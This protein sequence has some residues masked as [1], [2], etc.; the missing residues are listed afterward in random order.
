MQKQLWQTQITET[1]TSDLEGIGQ[2]REVNGKIY[3]WV[4]NT[5]S[6]TALALGAACC[7][8]FSDAG[9]FLKNVKASA[10]AN[11]N[12]M[13]GIVTSTAG[14]AAGSYGWIQVFG[15]YVDASVFQSQTTAGV[16]GDIYGPVNAVAYLD[17]AVAGGTAAT[18]PRHA[19]LMEA[20]ATVTTGAAGSF[21]VFVNCL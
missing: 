8:V 17:R 16:A 20:V 15:A 4:K 13:A 11:L 9:D 14:I 10:T 3:R 6:S 7:H 12:A 2:T 19:I 21:N 18:R 5:E 1:S